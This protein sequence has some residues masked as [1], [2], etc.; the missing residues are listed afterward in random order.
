MIFLDHAWFFAQV[1]RVRDPVR[2][3]Y[4]TRWYIFCLTVYSEDN[5]RMC[6][7]LRPILQFFFLA[8]KVKIRSS[9]HVYNILRVFWQRCYA[10]KTARD[11][12]RESR[13][14]TG[15]GNKLAKLNIIRRR[16]KRNV[17][18][19]VHERK[20]PSLS[21]E[22][23][24][25]PHP[26]PRRMRFIREHLLHAHTMKARNHGHAIARGDLFL[27]NAATFIIRYRREE[28]PPIVCNAR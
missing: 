28:D 6:P 16:V 3:R 2:R 8:R 23:F 14:T 22:D 12:Q 24:P 18:V 9:L 5:I 4:K 25:A 1:Q 20:R 10:L 21:R 26:H 15:V 7:C 19:L 17:Y 11:C 13:L 27:N